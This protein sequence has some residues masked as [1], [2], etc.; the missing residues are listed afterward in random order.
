MRTRSIVLRSPLARRRS[1]VAVASLVAAAACGNDPAG[2]D[3]VARFAGTYSLRRLNGAPLPFTDT[4]VLPD[5]FVYV[6]ETLTL[7]RDGGGGGTRTTR[8]RPSGAANPVVTT[9]A[10][11][12]LRWRADGDTLVRVY[13][14]TQTEFS[15]PLWVAGPDTLV[16]GFR[17]DTLA[18]LWVRERQ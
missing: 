2:P 14:G 11:P 16:N 7:A 18:R 13:E 6:A 10:L 3:A 12:S 4:S 9:S 15:M 8:Y 1:L 5:S 17:S